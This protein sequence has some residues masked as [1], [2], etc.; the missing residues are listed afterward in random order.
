MN[1]IYGI[2]GL[3]S[4]GA[5]L[6]MYLLVLILQSKQTPKSVAFIHGLFV[7]TALIMLIIYAVN[8]GPGLMESI[9]LFV[10]AAVGGL[11]LIYRDVTGKSM[12]KWLAIGHGLLAIAGFVFLLCYAFCSK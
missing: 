8:N 1:N 6:G 4:L 10:M 3:F 9:V 5:L 2:I 11:T 7:A 12:P